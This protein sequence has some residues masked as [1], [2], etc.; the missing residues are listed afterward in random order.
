MNKNIHPLVC[1]GE[2]LWDIRPSGTQPGGA[3]MN[4]AYHLQQLQKNPAIITKTGNDSEGRRLLELFTLKNINTGH[5]QTDLQ[6]PTG[7]VYGTQDPKGDMSYDIV[8]PSAWDFIE[9]HEAFTDLM[10][11]ATYFVYGSLAAR[12]IRSRKTLFELLEVAPRKVFDINLRA[13]HY[14]KNVLLDL[15][16]KA[17]L[18]K[19][20]EDEL[21]LT[22]PWFCTYTDP[23]DQV[24]SISEQLG[25]TLFVV[26]RGGDGA[27]LYRD[28]EIFSH[29]GIKVNVA[30]TVGSGDAFL[31]ALL[32]GLMDQDPPGLI[33]ENAVKLGSFVATQKGGMPDYDVEQVKAIAS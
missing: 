20:N 28:G 2:V 22:A 14:E 3:P 10:A 6:Y 19:M 16:K 31:A 24:R 4:V 26:T 23:Q 32:A 7:K 15:L 21:A 9:W 18:L 5:I 11:N 29:P 13:P 30:D 12:N 33:L 17:D 1:F 8:Q 25:L 27:I